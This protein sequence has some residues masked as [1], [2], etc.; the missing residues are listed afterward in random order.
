MKI[1]IAGR[2]IEVPKDVAHQ[3]WTEEFARRVRN[4]GF[5]WAK[6]QLK[7]KHILWRQFVLKERAAARKKSAIPPQV[8]EKH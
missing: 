6:A 5:A 3:I 7:I 1:K 2:K 4:G 8:S